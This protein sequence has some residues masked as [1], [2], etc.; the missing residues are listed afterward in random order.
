M[1]YLV[2]VLLL[3]LLILIHEIGHFLAAAALGIPVERFSIGFGPKLWSFKRK[4][5]EY[6]ISAVPLGGYVLPAVRDE[7][8]L[9]QIPWGKRI[10]FCLGGPAAN[11]AL[12]VVL[13]MVLNLMAGDVSMHGIFVKPVVQTAE[14]LCRIVTG[15]PQLFA[16]PDALSGVVGIVA[17]GGEFVRSDVTRAVHFTILLSVNLAVFNLLPIPVLD[18]GKIVLYLL[19]KL[20]RKAVRLYVPLTVIGVVLIVALLLYATALDIGRIVT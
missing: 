20:H 3:A 13:F 4:E 17:A 14:L 5:T 9:L 15:L 10:L 12:P 6:W 2:V 18:G 19:E 11:L 8:E 7:R 16:R 1:S